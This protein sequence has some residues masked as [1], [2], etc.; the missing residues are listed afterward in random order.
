MSNIYSVGSENDYLQSNNTRWC[1]LTT[2]RMERIAGQAIFTQPLPS[3][4]PF[5]L[6]TSSFTLHIVSRDGIRLSIGSLIKLARSAALHTL[7]CVCG[8]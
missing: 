6:L 1:T 5:A 8:G 2:D 4:S 7:T 3:S